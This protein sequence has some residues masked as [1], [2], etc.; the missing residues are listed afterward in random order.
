MDGFSY[1]K[2]T[3]VLI[4]QCNSLMRTLDP[5]VM[6]LFPRLRRRAREL[7][8]SALMGCAYYYQAYMIYYMGTGY[9][10]FRPVL[11]KAVRYLLHSGD[12]EMLA[13]VYNF[14]A[15][16]A[17]NNGNYDVAYNYYMTGKRFADMTEETTIASV[18]IGINLGRLYQEMGQPE[19]AIRYFRK[20][21]RDIA[22]GKEHFRYRRTVLA[23][24]LNS[25]T[26]QLSL[27]DVSQAQ[28]LMDRA[29]KEL[30]A[31]KDDAM[32]DVQATASFLRIRLLLARGRT[33]E[34]KKLLSK[35]I[36]TIRLGEQVHEYIEDIGYFCKSLTDYKLYPEVKRLIAAID[37]QIR[38]TDITHIMRIF[39]EVKVYF[40]ETTGDEKNLLESLKEQNEL[41]E[42]QRSEQSN[43]YRYS[44]E[45]IDLT[46]ELRE[47]QESIRREN[48]ELMLRVRTDALTGLPNR[49]TMVRELEAAFER[50]FRNGTTLGVE[51]LDI[52][53]FKEYNDTYGHRAGDRCLERIAGQLEK[54]GKKNGT[55][56]ARYGGD[57]FVI[58]YEGHTDQEIIEAAERIERGIRSLRMK[59]DGNYPLQLVTVSQ[60]ICNDV[61][62]EKNKL[63]DFLSEADQALYS[64][65]RSRELQKENVSICL[66][67]RPETFIR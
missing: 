3:A 30:A 13:N 24:L 28:K 40:Y 12:Y 15:V 56:C 57:E 64:I 2:K 31:A 46:R 42:R 35:L 36:K 44:I 45:M 58:V 22:S 50:A 27:G 23:A 29:E 14:I 48:E 47:E 17:H 54:C 33:D 51:I 66:K 61:P 60:G 21:L 55:F 67:K 9:H 53:C 8:D 10:T 43:T 65:K 19:K 37:P 38:A 16:D 6:N 20:A 49:Y 25:V 18:M 59:H 7:G 39:S 11:T 52:D 5:A 41:H 26:A 1:D 34:A 4:E 63:W 62:M 32:P